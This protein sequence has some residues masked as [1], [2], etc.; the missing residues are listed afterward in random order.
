MLEF[1][2]FTQIERKRLEI[3]PKNSLKMIAKSINALISLTSLFLHIKFL[4][5]PTHNITVIIISKVSL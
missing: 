5:N 3:I 4:Q 2:C 1:V